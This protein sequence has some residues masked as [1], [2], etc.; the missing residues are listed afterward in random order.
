MRL[1]KPADNVI[2]ADERIEKDFN[3]LKEDDWVKKA[4]LRAITD[5]KENAFCGERI[6][7]EKIPKVYIQKYGIDNLL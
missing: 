2:F 6:K 7:K 4:I 3:S 1:F 5:F